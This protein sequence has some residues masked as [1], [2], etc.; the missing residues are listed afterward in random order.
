MKAWL[1]LAAAAAAMMFGGSPQ[2]ASAQAAGGPSLADSMRTVIDTVTAQGPVSFTGSVTDSTNN[3]S[4]SY[5]RRVVVTSF[6]TDVPACK[7]YFHF[8]EVTPGNPST[9][10]DGWV[11]FA[12]VQKTI[13]ETLDAELVR[14]NAKSDHPQWRVSVQPPIYVASAVRPDGTTNDF[15]FYDQG[16]AMRVADAIRRATLLCGGG[17]GSP[18]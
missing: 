14:I 5:S 13:V 4:W 7:L 8:S 2:V 10:V 16:M 12:G 9:E 18:K 1:S 11:P 6:R 3:K 17:K 15:D